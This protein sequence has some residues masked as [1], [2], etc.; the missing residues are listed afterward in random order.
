[1]RGRYSRSRITSVGAKAPADDSSDPALDGAKSASANS[2]TLLSSSD[3]VAGAVCSWW[4]SRSMIPLDGAPSLGCFQPR[5]RRTKCAS[6]A[7]CRG[8]GGRNPCRRQDPFRPFFVKRRGFRGP[9]RL[10]STSCPLDNRFRDCLEREPA[11]VPR[12]LPPVTGFRRSFALRYDEEG[13]D[14][15]AS[16]SSSLASARRHAPLV[17]FCNRNEPQARPADR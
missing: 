6:D 7:P 11:T 14:P 15:A 1:M 8:A 2:T 17:D 12:A 4:G 16:A 13:L 9:K 10:S 5:A 3:E